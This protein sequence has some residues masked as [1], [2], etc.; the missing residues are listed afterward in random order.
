[1]TPPTTTPPTWSPPSSPPPTT[2]PAAAACTATY[3][4]TGQWSGGFQG[5]IEV[6]A[7]TTPIRGWTVT[8]TLAGGQQITQAW[9]ATLTTS[10]S[11]ATARN[12]SY[13]GAL[14]AGAK[15][16]FGFIGSGPHSTPTPRC[17]A[18]A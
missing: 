14:A 18:T 15:A 2:P 6:T 5:E 13:N 10:G 7:G 8:W 4:S 17:G 12:V 16:S 9:N 1:T 11:T 3:R